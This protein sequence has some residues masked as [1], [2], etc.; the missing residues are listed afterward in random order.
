MLVS[1]GFFAATLLA[2]LIA[3]AAWARAVRLT[4]HRIRASLPINET[5]IRA[6]KDQLRATHAVVVHQLEKKIERAEMSAARQRVELNRRE[7]RIA[8]LEDESVK[9]TAQRDENRNARHVLAQ[10]LNER[11]PRAEDRL[12]E[13]RELLKA[14]DSQIAKFVKAATSQHAALAEASSQIKQQD[15][16]LKRLQAAMTARQ[17]AGRQRVPTEALEQTIALQSEVRELRE[18][19]AT[20]SRLI[21]RIQ[22]AERTQLE[23][24]DAAAVARSLQG[25]VQAAKSANGSA[26]TINDD[27]PKG[28]GAR[29]NR[30]RVAL[31]REKETTSRL[32][33]E[34]ANAYDRAAKLSAHYRQ[35][36]GNLSQNGGIQVALPDSVD[37]NPEK[38]T[39]YAATSEMTVLDR[40]KSAVSDTSD[41]AHIKD[42]KGLVNGGA[43]TASGNGKV[44]RLGR[45]PF[46]ENETSDTS[47][48]VDVKPGATNVSEEKRGSS[49]TERIK[50]QD[51]RQDAQDTITSD[52]V[53][54]KMP[55][56]APV[57]SPVKSGTLLQ[58]LKGMEDV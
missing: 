6:E 16:E 56:Q 46:D 32:R 10:T 48:T 58:R 7:A 47:E 52:Y 42:E 25:E 38:R 45:S 36:L 34:L 22:E 4:S 26:D 27:A 54:E 37:P 30:W 14:R 12:R 41:I 3:P 55:L 13:T 35:E 17:Y 31:Q 40:A 8:E 11:L 15:E 53:R 1:L 23:D 29:F 50:K 9:I 20:Q 2:L 18:R 57:P 24:K 51:I 21:E 28:F 33:V 39:S 44:S 43:A 19:T 5:E 49:L